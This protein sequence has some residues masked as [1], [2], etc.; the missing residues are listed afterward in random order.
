MAG[1]TVLDI[2]ILSNSDMNKRTPWLP[3]KKNK[4]KCPHCNGKGKIQVYS[5]YFTIEY[6]NCSRCG[7]KGFY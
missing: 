3:T 1:R 6:Q 4:V 2:V 5:I 7:G